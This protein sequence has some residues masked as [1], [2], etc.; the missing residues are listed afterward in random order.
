MTVLEGE[1]LGPGMNAG[2]KQEKSVRR[3]F[4]RTLARA[5]DRIPFAEDVVAA[6]YTALDTNTPTRVRMTLMGALAY[7]VLPFDSIPDVLALVG[8]TDD[9]AVLTLAIAAVRSHMTDA[10][11]LAARRA[12]AAMKEGDAPET[13]A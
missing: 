9:I 6:Y 3:N 1:I 8:F 7:F 12:I 10:H 13:A 5:A 4:W 11:R 2:Y